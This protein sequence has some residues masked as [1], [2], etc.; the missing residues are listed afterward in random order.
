MSVGL[1]VVAVHLA[2]VVTLIATGFTAATIVRSLS[3]NDN[4]MSVVGTTQTAEV[5][6]RAPCGDAAF[7]EGELPEGRLAYPCP[8]TVNE[9]TWR[10]RPIEVRASIPLTQTKA[11]LF[12]AGFAVV[13][14][15]AL[16]AILFSMRHF[17]RAAVNKQVFVASNA[18]HLARIGALVV[19][20]PLVATIGEGM[21]NNFLP[22]TAAGISLFRVQLGLQDNWVP[23]VL[24]GLVILAVSSAFRYGVKLQE[25][26]QAVI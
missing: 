25:F 22:D 14:L 17:A 15:A 12:F 1:L 3:G 13:Q 26:E 23:L 18:H 2:M 4:A 11:K 24:C 9:A 8:D 7:I 10:P 21:S 20:L 19:G 6:F 16:W 5:E